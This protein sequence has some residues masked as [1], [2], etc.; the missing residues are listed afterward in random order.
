[1][2]KL[3]RFASRDSDNSRTSFRSKK[4]DKTVKKVDGY[5]V[6]YLGFATLTDAR[7]VNEVPRAIENVKTSTV[8]QINAHISFQGNHLNVNDGDHQVILSSPL[9]NISQCVQHS[10]KGFNDCFG[11]AFNSGPWIKQCHIFQAKSDKE[12]SNE[13]H[14]TLGHPASSLH[15]M[16]DG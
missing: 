12:V 16:W 10:Q 8:D 15:V 11:L 1:M 14:K 3:M 6:L 9:I 4:S 2:K 13:K 5:G 7:A